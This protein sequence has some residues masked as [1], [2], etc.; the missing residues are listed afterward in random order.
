MEG[1]Q[2]A[3]RDDRWFGIGLTARR[4]SRTIRC[5]FRSAW[6]SCKRRRRVREHD[7]RFGRRSRFHRPLENSPRP[8]LTTQSKGALADSPRRVARCRKQIRICS[9]QE[10]EV[11]HLGIDD[12]LTPE[13]ALHD[14]RVDWQLVQIAFAEELPHDAAVLARCRLNRGEDQPEASC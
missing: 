5:A 6:H 7:G 2:E 11:I 9:D 4:S 1:R 12:A 14:K 10:S 3:R 8:V 13:V